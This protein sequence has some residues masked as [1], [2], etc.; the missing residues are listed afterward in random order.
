YKRQFV[1]TQKGTRLCRPSEIVLDILDSQNLGYFAKEDG[2]IIIDEQG[3]R[4]K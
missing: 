2:E 1:V 4:I 3:R